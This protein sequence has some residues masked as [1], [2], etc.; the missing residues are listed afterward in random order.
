[1]MCRSSQAVFRCIGRAVATACLSLPWPVVASADTYGFDYVVDA[2]TVVF[3]GSY[4]YSRTLNPEDVGTLYRISFGSG[5][6]RVLFRSDGGAL[7]AIE[8]AP[9]GTLV[10]F[11]ER[12]FE[13]HVAE[14]RSN[15][16]SREGG[17]LVVFHFEDSVLTI[18]DVNGEVFERIPRVRR[19]VWS[20][21][22]RRI[23]YLTGDYREDGGWDFA[24]TGA[25]I[26][27][28]D[29]T[30]SSRVYDG[31][32]E[33]SW[34]EWDNAIYIGEFVDATIDWRVLRVAPDTEDAL[35]TAYRGVHFSPDGRHYYRPGREGTE[36]ELYETATGARLPVDTR[37]RWTGRV[38]ESGRP[39]GWHD[40]R[41]LILPSPLPGDDADYLYDIETQALRRATGWV[42]SARRSADRVLVVEGLAVRERSPA[43]FP[44]VP[45]D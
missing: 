39:R 12:Y 44:A 26:Y 15:F 32:Y 22:G 38:A 34:A 4:V 16:R 25:W 8:A 35:P 10:A 37:I 2:D 3:G 18:V 17:E 24:P 45:R 11:L 1:M 13:E 36:L 7:T 29:T 42:L 6:R 23:A 19:Y 41:T 5:E 27:D 30:R 9:R 14:E 40:E 33:I 20:P 31:G 28:L 21:D 43:G